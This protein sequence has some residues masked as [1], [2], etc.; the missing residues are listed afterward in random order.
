M[1]SNCM[2]RIGLR[3]ALAQ[4]I[5]RWMT[6]TPRGVW[7]EKIH[8]VPV[9]EYV[10]TQSFSD[11]EPESCSLMDARLQE[12]PESTAIISLGITEFGELK[13]TDWQLCSSQVVTSLT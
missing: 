12:L 4:A 13:P 8:V 3:T 9:S 7:Q 1:I 10:H 5:E 6:F 11:T 2:G